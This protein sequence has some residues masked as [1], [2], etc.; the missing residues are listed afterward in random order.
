MLVESCSGLEGLL[1]IGDV[2]ADSRLRPMALK[3]SSLGEVAISLSKGVMHVFGASFGTALNIVPSGIFE[4]NL[5]ANFHLLLRAFPIEL[6]P[7]VGEDDPNIMLF[8]GSTNACVVW[9][10]DPVPLRLKIDT[11]LLAMLFELGS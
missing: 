4:S 11:L 10:G 8:P 3:I 2:G 5:P 1:S 9:V 7:L 6:D